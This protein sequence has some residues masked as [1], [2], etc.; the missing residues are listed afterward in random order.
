MLL[1]K[2]WNGEKVNLSHLKVFGCVAY[3]HVPNQLR[4]KFDPKS[5]PYIFV[6]YS[7]ESKGYRL[8]DV[9]N[10]G[11]IV[12]ARN[13]IFLE[14]KFKIE[15]MNPKVKATDQIKPTVIVEEPQTSLLM[16]NT[17]S[18]GSEDLT[19]LGFSGPDSDSDVS[20]EQREGPPVIPRRSS[21]ER[22]R[23]DFP[24][25]EVYLSTT[26]PVIPSSYKEAT[27]GPDRE[28][29]VA[30]MK[31]EYQALM[32]NEVCT[33]VK[34]PKDKKIVECKWV[35]NLKKGSNGNVKHKSRLVAKG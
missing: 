34:K 10:P 25:Y 16:D 35:Y 7:N 6:G 15:D 18:D 33:L 1:L 19:F 22:K 14:D 5:E 13:V 2:K 17:S 4:K 23:K 30:S 20:D 27:G 12:I 3:A 32:Y 28:M 9:R 29:W 31:E 24:G 26:A 8:F 11:K 21:R